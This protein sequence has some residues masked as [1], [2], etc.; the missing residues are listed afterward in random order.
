[1][2]LPLILSLIWID[3]SSVRADSLH[4]NSSH[5][6]FSYHDLIRKYKDGDV[7]ICNDNISI[8]II[9]VTALEFEID[10]RIRLH[11]NNDTE[12]DSIFFQYKPSIA[13]H[14]RRNL[15]EEEFNFK[16]LGGKMKNAF[17]DLKDKA[18]K[19][20]KEH[21]E[22]KDKKR[23]ESEDEED[24]KNK[25]KQKEKEDGKTENIECCRDIH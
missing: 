20:I 16:S 15:L 12:F 13:H 6:D 23:K 18:K 5:Y 17:H 24:D 8:K 22:E 1:M 14:N 2:S 21:K 10:N 25:K 19:K 9:N 11:F 4:S 3:H 7:L